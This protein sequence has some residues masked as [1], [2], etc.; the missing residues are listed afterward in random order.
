M[1]SGEQGGRDGQSDGKTE[2]T[3]AEKPQGRTS[4]CLIPTCSPLGRLLRDLMETVSDRHESFNEG[5]DDQWS[6]SKLNLSK[7]LSSLD[8][9]NLGGP[10]FHKMKIHG[11]H[12]QTLAAPGAAWH[13]QL[14]SQRAWGHLDILR[15][16]R[17]GPSLSSS[18]GRCCGENE[19][20]LEVLT[21][22]HSSQVGSPAEK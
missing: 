11:D 20:R 18:V 7:A 17:R 8:I 13:P 21:A 3:E 9:V 4:L 16:P 2:T 19:E 22:S 12:S 1:V 15:P 6:P 10:R 14:V 5:S